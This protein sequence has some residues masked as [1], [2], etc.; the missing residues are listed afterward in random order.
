[1][2]ILEKINKF[3]FILILVLGI[4]GTIVVATFRGI[5]ASIL[6]AYE[7][8]SQSASNDFKIDKEKQDQALASF[9]ERPKIK[10]EIKDE[11]KSP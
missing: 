3:Y 8:T 4:S 7:I 2:K 1:M 9:Y 10:L 11:V 6:T 5:F